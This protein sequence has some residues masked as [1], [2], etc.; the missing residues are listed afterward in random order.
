MLSSEQHERISLSQVKL[1]SSQRSTW[2]LLFL[3]AWSFLFC[4]HTLLKFSLLDSRIIAVR[5][6]MCKNVR[7]TIKLSISQ[8]MLDQHLA[9]HHENSKDKTEKVTDFHLKKFPCCLGEGKPEFG[10]LWILHSA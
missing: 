7:Y 4:G 10:L 2:K 1:K 3:G 8:G 5:E 9:I 6:S